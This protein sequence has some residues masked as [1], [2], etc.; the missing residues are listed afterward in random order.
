MSSAKPFMPLRMSVWPVAIQIRT[1]DG[2]GITSGQAA[3]AAG[4][5]DPGSHSS[6]TCCAA[7]STRKDGRKR[8]AS[9]D[10]TPT[11][12]AAYAGGVPM[13]KAVIFSNI[14]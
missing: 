10:R 13:L 6:E 5:R 11:G 8:A 4:A 1:F 7:A 9:R 3:S 12:K 2:T 14:G